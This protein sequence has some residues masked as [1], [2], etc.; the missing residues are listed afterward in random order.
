MKCCECGHQALV[1]EVED[2]GR[3]T[4][5]HQETDDDEASQESLLSDPETNF[6]NFFCSNLQL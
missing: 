6:I 3:E 5:L 4:E 2:D 1:V